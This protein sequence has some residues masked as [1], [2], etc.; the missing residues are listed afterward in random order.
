[1]FD[2]FQGKVALVTG[3]SIGIGRMIAEG[4]AVNGCK[5]YITS[6]KEDACHATAAELNEIAAGTG[7]EVIGFASDLSVV[8][9][10]EVAAAYVS[11]REE[12]LHIL[13][14]NAGATWYFF[15]NSCS[16]SIEKCEEMRDLPLISSIL[17]SKSQESWGNQGRLV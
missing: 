3:G 11:E 2:S 1:M 8:E 5:V 6:R 13:I 7:G 14:N 4:L 12:K 10:C 17:L 15:H 9:G 16:F